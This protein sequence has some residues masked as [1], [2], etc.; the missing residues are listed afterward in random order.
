MTARANGFGSVATVSASP[1]HLDAKICQSRLRIGQKHSP[2]AWF[3]ATGMVKSSRN[4]QKRWAKAKASGRNA[5]LLRYFQKKSL[6][7]VGAALKT[8]E[9]AAQKRLTR[10]VERLRHFFAQ[11]GITVGATGL[12]VALSSNSVHA[13]PFSLAVTVTA[14]AKTA[15][16]STPTL[17]LIN[18]TLKIMISTKAK[19][20]LENDD[21]KPSVNIT[22]SDSGSFGVTFLLPLTPELGP[23]AR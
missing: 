17:T 1:A 2:M 23:V 13:A 14:A 19:V 6:S 22:R 5:L 16:V 9:N 8:S 4:N 10:A 12:V 15:S 11:R 18:G 20:V 3:L 7:E 21:W